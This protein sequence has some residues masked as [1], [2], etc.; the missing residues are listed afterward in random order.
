MSD[1]FLKNSLKYLLKLVTY[2][3]N[4][5]LKTSGEE[6]LRNIW[7]LYL[8]I[9]KLIMEISGKNTPFVCYSLR[10]SRSLKIENFAVGVAYNTSGC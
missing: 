8:R 6:I 7:T 9:L 10:K 5:Y 3:E 1:L 2:G 4:H